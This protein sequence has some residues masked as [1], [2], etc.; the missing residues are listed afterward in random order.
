MARRGRMVRTG[1]VNVGAAVVVVVTT[2]V[3]VVGA[4]VSVVAVG[5]VVEV[6]AAEVGDAVPSSRSDWLNQNLI[7]WV[8]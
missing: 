5:V 2:L 6:G 8:S 1:P 4:V 7:T 3:V